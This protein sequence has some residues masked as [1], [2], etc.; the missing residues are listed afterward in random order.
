[1][2]NT[3]N[4]ISRRIYWEESTIFF[5]TVSMILINFLFNKVCITQRKKNKQQERALTIFFVFLLKCAKKMKNNLTIC[6][7][8]LSACYKQSI[9]RSI[10][11]S[12]IVSKN[13]IC[14][15]NKNEMFATKCSLYVLVGNPI[16]F[17]YYF[18]R[19]L[20]I[21]LIETIQMYKIE[22]SLMRVECYFIVVKIEFSV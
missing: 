14:S 3:T 16:Y 9:L 20:K 6:S 11:I 18:A 19:V 15:V 2:K 21:I 12:N 17:I 22:R 1:M 4:F 7:Y 8:L 10:V 5:S 13:Q